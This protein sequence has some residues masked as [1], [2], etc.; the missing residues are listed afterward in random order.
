MT[1]DWRDVVAR[2]ECP[3]LIV[4]GRDSQVW[5]YEHAEAAVRD[6][7]HGR[8]VVIEDAGHT[9]TWDQPDAFH[10]VL[11]DFIASLTETD[12]GPSSLSP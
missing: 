6:L 1:P 5:S 10:E 3:V 7:P 8:A 4:A 2:A 11:L 12:E 9:V